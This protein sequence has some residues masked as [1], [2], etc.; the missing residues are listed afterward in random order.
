MG[1][2]LGMALENYRKIVP[3]NSLLT[4]FQLGENEGF[5]LEKLNTTI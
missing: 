4:F 2:K 1:H 5:T 3:Q